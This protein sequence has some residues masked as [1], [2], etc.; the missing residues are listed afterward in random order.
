MRGSK[1]ISGIRAFLTKK[2]GLNKSSVS[3]RIKAFKLGYRYGL[4]SDYDKQALGN[5][6]EE[7][8]R[9]TNNT[10]II[11]AFL[12]GERNAE[13]EKALVEKSL[14]YEAKKRKEMQLL[15]EKQIEAEVIELKKVRE[16][17]HQD[18]LQDKSR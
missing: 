15:A 6:V 4:V 17:N 2:F 18:R 13:N 14:K 9:H 11:N 7:I 5:L 10:K 8:L 3:A 1:E 12:E 16:E